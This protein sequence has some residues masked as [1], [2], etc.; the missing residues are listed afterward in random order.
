[1]AEM[2]ELSEVKE[3]VI[4]VGVSTD[5]NDDTQKSLDEL[6]E[7]VAT[8]GAVV[9]GRVVQNLDQIHPGTYVG[10][11]KLEEIK[12]LLIFKTRYSLACS[13]VKREI[14]KSMATKIG[15]VI[16]QIQIKVRAMFWELMEKDCRA[17]VRT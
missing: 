3:R 10:K 17:S 9:V 8:A 14:I 13:G 4:L 7:L 5:D 12:N 2:I 1:M 16:M 6:E 11:G 15:L